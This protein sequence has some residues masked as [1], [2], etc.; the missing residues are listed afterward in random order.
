MKKETRIIFVAHLGALTAVLLS[1]GT[2]QGY[3]GQ[4][5]DD[6][7]V[8]EAIEQGVIDSHP[9]PLRD[10]WKGWVN[11]GEFLSYRS[12]AIVRW[13]EVADAT[14]MTAEQRAKAEALHRKF[15]NVLHTFKEATKPAT[16]ELGERIRMAKEKGNEDLA[17]TLTRLGHV[18]THQKLAVEGGASVELLRLLSDE[19]LAEWHNYRVAKHARNA[20]RDHLYNRSVYDEDLEDALNLTGAQKERIEE[21]IAEVV[22]VAYMPTVENIEDISALA[23]YHEN[24]RR[25]QAMADEM[26]YPWMMREALDETQ[27]APLKYPDQRWHISVSPAGGVFKH[28]ETVTARVRF[29]AEREDK[30]ARIRY[31][32]D[33]SRPTA[34]SKL[35]GEPL[36]ITRDTTVR[37]SCFLDGDLLPGGAAVARFA[38]LDGPKDT[39]PGLTYR[40]YLGQWKRLPRFTDLEPAGRG[41]TKAI[42]LGLTEKGGDFAL[43]FSGYLNIDETGEYVFYVASDDGSALYLDG[44]R[45]VNNDGIHASREKS[46][47]VRLDRGLHLVRVEYFDA[48]GGKELIVQWQGPG[49]EKQP[50]AGDVLRH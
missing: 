42:I 34:D 48:G 12:N 15:R 45:I 46:G 30:G 39:E 4:Q 36:T 9:F 26:V 6:Q 33:G 40:H 21:K 24:K 13:E 41:V 11:S 31:T 2:V 19:Q 3:H 22:R 23:I 10:P 49:F 18:Q 16:E 14:S 8:R 27:R 29:E 44:E 28:G 32:L 37:A 43:V 5:K 17:A 47:T 38:F 35:Y 25:A 20:M 7:K 1:A 50:L